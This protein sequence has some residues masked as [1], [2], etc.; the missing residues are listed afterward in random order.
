MRE[1]TTRFPSIARGA[2]L[3]AIVTAT[4]AN[5]SASDTTGAIPHPQIAYAGTYSYSDELGG[6][7]IV[8]S[9]GNGTR[10]DPV[11]I[12]QELFS[13]SAVT[14]VIRAARPIRPFDHSGLY[15]SGFIHMRLEILNNSG[16]AWQEVE[17]E[18]QERLGESSVFSDGLSFD[19]R[20]TDSA[21]VHSS[22]FRKW[23]R[24]FEPYDR[25]LFED[26]SV[27]PREI[28]TLGFFVTDFTPR[29]VFYLRIDPR[30][31]FS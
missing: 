1:A 17:L 16:V 14:M 6:F 5:A 3:I 29:W 7:A 19:Q 8:A 10:D 26:G 28:V 4:L 20:R 11:V 25:L 21:N 23:D 2:G 27:D 15:A 22:H 9:G 13:A 31:P 12:Q 18:L 24:D 30:I